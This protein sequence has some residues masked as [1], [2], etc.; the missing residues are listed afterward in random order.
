[1]ADPESAPSTADEAPQSDELRSLLEYLKRNR[2]FDFA[3]YKRTSLERRIRKRMDDVKID[4]YA[5][6]EDYLEV[7]PAEFTGLFN[8]IL[9]NVTSFF[10]DMPA[11]EFLADDV[12]P[13]LLGDIPE[14][15]PVRVW[16]AACASGE[17]AYT[18]AIL[19]A[20]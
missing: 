20:E 10:R 14:D 12:I 11:W 13:E 4:S 6:Y 9:I 8:T 1:M 2:G 7:Q 17:E 19:L 16:C 5:A 15:Q 18:T 3:G